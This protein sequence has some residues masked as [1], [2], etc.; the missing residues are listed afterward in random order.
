MTWSIGAAIRARGL[1]L[2]PVEVVSVSA[3][4]NHNLCLLHGGKRPVII[5]IFRRDGVVGI[6]MA[7]CSHDAESIEKRYPNAIAMALQQLSAGEGIP[8]DNTGGTTV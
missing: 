3:T 4:G 7:G 2:V 8:R 6:D 5:L 1:S